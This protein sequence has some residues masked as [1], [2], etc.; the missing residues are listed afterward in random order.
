MRQP[1]A[2]LSE[3]ASGPSTESVRRRPHV[4]VEPEKDVS[5]SRSQEEDTEADHAGEVNKRKRLEWETPEFL[6]WIPANFQRTKLKA[7][8]SSNILWPD[9]AQ[10]SFLILI[11]SVLSPPSDPFPAVL[12][13]ELLI[14]LFASLTWAW[15]C[16]GIKF[17]DLARTNRNLN[18]GLGDVVHGHYIEVALDHADILST[19]I[20]LTTAVLFPFPYYNIGQVVV[21]PLVFHSAVAL[22]TSVIIFPTTISAHFTNNLAGVLVPL[23]TA[24]DQHKAILSTSTRDDAFPAAAELIART[25]AQADGALTPLAAAARLLRSDLIYGRF[26]PVDFIPFHDLARRAA[27]RA[28][29]M[30]VYFSLVDPTRP[31]FPAT[32]VPSMPTTPVLSRAPSFE[33]L[34]ELTMKKTHISQSPSHPSSPNHSRQSSHVNLSKHVHHSLLHFH[35]GRHRHENAVGVFESQRYMNLEA[36]RLNDPHSEMHTAQM[37]DG[38]SECCYN[39][40]D[41]CRNGLSAVQEWLSTVR[42]GRIRFLFKTKEAKERWSTQLAEHQKFRD[43]LFAVIERFRTDER[44]RVLEAYRP[45][46]DQEHPEDD[47]PAHRYL[48]QAY[49]YQY[50]LI[51]FA[52]IILEMMD[53]MISAEKMRT[54]QRLWTPVQRLFRS[55]NWQLADDNIHVEDEDPGQY[56]RTLALHIPMADNT[57]IAS[58]GECEF[59]DIRTLVLSYGC[60]RL[61]SIMGQVTIARFQGDTTFALIARVLATFLGGVLGT[62]MWYVS[63]SPPPSLPHP[64]YTIFLPSSGT[65]PA[66]PGKATPT[67]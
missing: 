26:S 32:P 13:R 67:A 30:G 48:F 34:E 1:D 61:C 42:S 5:G 66:A 37:I 54:T 6:Q 53:E 63:L 3:K 46:F 12:E 43:E 8:I 40:L 10:A 49:V 50:H 56:L 18:V 33:G 51:Q 52:L 4:T 62:V 64:Y 31:R 58:F 45:A 41:C 38:L 7:T 60:N 65:S 17:A 25:V 27:V 55:N 44:Y 23:I 20:S 29:G 22:V 35:P 28:N 14:M 11:A 21:L 59:V 47:P 24:L 15:S 2:E 16:L 19:D 9:V 57:R 39:L 36:T